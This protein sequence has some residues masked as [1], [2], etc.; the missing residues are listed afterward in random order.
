MHANFDG[1]SDVN[2]EFDWMDIG[3]DL[4]LLFFP[5][6]ALFATWQIFVVRRRM[7]ELEEKQIHLYKRVQTIT[8]QVEHAVNQQLEREHSLVQDFLGLTKKLE[9]MEMKSF[10]SGGRSVETL[11]LLEAGMPVEKLADACGLSKTEEDLLKALQV[12]HNQEN[13]G[14]VETY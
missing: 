12:A 1:Y 14:K 3:I 5:L 7:A 6:L 13:G 11:K 9:S 4:F 8:E 10:S 2:I